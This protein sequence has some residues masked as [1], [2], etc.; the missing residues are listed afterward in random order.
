MLIFINLCRELK[1]SK[2]SLTY[3]SRL[4]IES[5]QKAGAQAVEPGPAW[6]ESRA[7]VKEESQVKGR[8]LVLPPGGESRCR[9]LTSCC[10]PFG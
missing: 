3:A 4:R 6:Q 10:H 1:L 8:L 2:V 5:I 9:A 7:G